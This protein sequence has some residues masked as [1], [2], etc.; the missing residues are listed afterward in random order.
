MGF[1]YSGFLLLGGKSVLEGKDTA[2]TDR[3]ITTLFIQTYSH[4]GGHPF[5]SEFGTKKEAIISSSLKLQG[6]ISS[7]N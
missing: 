2:D 3:Q 7:A 4:V 1:G 5:L 6:F